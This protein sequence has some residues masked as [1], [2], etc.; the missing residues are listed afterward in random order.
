MNLHSLY[1]FKISYIICGSPCEEL[2][3]AAFE[4]CSFLLFKF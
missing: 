3:P 1:N 2:I 4:T